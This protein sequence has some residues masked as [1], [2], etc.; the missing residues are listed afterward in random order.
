MSELA[1]QFALAQEQVNTLTERPT[2]EELLQLY[3]LYKQASEGDV[4]GPKPGMFDLKGKA[5]YQYWENNKGKTS[6]E[7]MQEYIELV[8]SLL[9][10]YPHES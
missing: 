5:K 10:K 6:E 2:N 3:G 1:S 9:E 7:A 4:N 8:Q